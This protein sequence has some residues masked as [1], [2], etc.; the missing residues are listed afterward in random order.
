MNRAVRH[1][2]FTLLL[3]LAC[4]SA[5]Q[6][7]VPGTARDISQECLFNGISGKGHNL[8][9]GTYARDFKTGLRDGARG[10]QI[11][12]P[13]GATVGAIYIQWHSLPLPL[14]IQTHD[15]A[16]SWVTVSSCDGDFYAQ[17]IPIPNLRDFRIVCRD[18]PLQQLSI[19]DMK[20]LT[21][22]TPPDTVQLWQKPGDKVDMM[23]IAGHPDDELLW[24]GGTL[25]TYAGEQHKNVLVICAAMNRSIRRLELLDCLWACGVRTHPIHCVLE[26]FSTTN[27][28]DVIRRWGG[29]EKLLEMF[30]GYYRRYKPD[31]VLLHDINGEYGHGIHR[32]VSWLGRECAELASDR[33]AYPD[34]VAK[35]GTWKIPK[36]YIHLY[37]ENVIQ[38]DWHQPLSAFGGKTAIEAAADA[39]YWHKTQTDHGWAV[40][41]GGDL[42]NSLF[43]LYRTLVG[44]DTEKKDFFENIPAAF[45]GSADP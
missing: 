11:T 10:L 6:A 8:T 37:P 20:V 45:S 36:I 43:G 13:Q 23:L 44:Q 3:F 21:P 19:C 39:M 30:T 38:M 2:F 32:T 29:Q 24:F 7:E 26:D 25:P 18:D 16:G 27:M 5:C 4:F 1:L 17:Y 31:V 22:G 28:N 12:A 9:D 35:Y 14:N 33:T 40:T 41:E 15:K 34:Q 42:D